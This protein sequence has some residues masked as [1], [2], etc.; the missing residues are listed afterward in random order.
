MRCEIAV[1]TATALGGKRTSA[2]QNKPK[3]NQKPH[4][5]RHKKTL[6]LVQI[7]DPKSGTQKRAP[8]AHKP[9]AFLRAPSRSDPFLGPKTGPQ[10][11]K[12]KNRKMCHKCDAQV[13]RE[14]SQQGD[15]EY[16]LSP[17]KAAKPGNACDMHPA[18]LVYALLTM[19]CL[20]LWMLQ[21]IQ[22]PT[23]SQTIEEKGGSTTCGTGSKSLG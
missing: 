10:F 15:E 20:F 4:Q 14:G 2:T 7:W 6:F 1:Q 3:T 18:L 23:A 17:S 22:S 13:R 11:S 9:Y 16:L 8:W 12:K 5:K 21:D 19:L